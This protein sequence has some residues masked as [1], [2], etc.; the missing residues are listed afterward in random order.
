VC[1]W[2]ESLLFGPNVHLTLFDCLY[3]YLSTGKIG[4]STLLKRLQCERE[5]LS[6]RDT[7]VQSLLASPEWKTA[8]WF[9]KTRRLYSSSVMAGY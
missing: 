4:S 9:S 5:H 3:L 2:H 8:V 1:V 6:H 7:T